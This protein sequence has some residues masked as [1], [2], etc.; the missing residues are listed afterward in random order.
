MVQLL[1]VWC[2]LGWPPESHHH[3]HHHQ[4]GFA[5]LDVAGEPTYGCGCGCGAC[6]PVYRL[7][8]RQGI[9]HRGAGALLYRF[10]W[11]GH[12]YER[13]GWAMCCR[14]CNPIYVHTIVFKSCSLQDLLPDTL[15]LCS[16]LQDLRWFLVGP[17]SGADSWVMR[18]CSWSCAPTWTI[19]K[20]SESGNQY[21]W[22]P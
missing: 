7:R 13:G 3:N 22:I 18:V 16:R 19:Q 5:R 21:N 4:S 14:R 20:P 15:M 12:T 17:F 6:R 10:D 9:D 11:H 1:H 8:D 2:C